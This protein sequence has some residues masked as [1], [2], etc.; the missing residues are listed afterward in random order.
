MTDFFFIN[1]R[2]LGFNFPGLTKLKEGVNEICVYSEGTQDKPL[3]C[4]VSWST[5]TMGGTVLT[6]SS[7]SENLKQGHH[8]QTHA[9]SKTREIGRLTALQILW[10]PKPLTLK[11][12]ESNLP[13][14]CCM[15]L[16]P[17][18][19]SRP[20]ICTRSVAKLR[21]SLCT[22]RQGKRLCKMFDIVL[23]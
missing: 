18:A 7:S 11:P 22:R 1:A 13:W 23:K 6:L 17:S 3:P 20:I 2:Y 21:C 19:N 16:K 8:Q 9:C 10:T 15:S 12:M 14:A 5:L 4:S